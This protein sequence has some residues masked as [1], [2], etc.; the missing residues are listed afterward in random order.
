MILPHL[1]ITLFALLSAAANAF[2]DEA[3]YVPGE[4]LVKYKE[5]TSD[6]DR[7]GFEKKEKLTLIVLIKSVKV[8]LYRLPEGVTVDDAI[9]AFSSLQI[10]EYAEPNFIRKPQA[11]NDPRYNEQWYLHNSGQEVNGMVGPAGVDIRWPEAM[12]IF[13]GTKDVVVAVVDSGVAVTHRELLPNTWFNL[14]EVDGSPGVD[15][16]GNGRIDDR[17]GYD[18]FDNDTSPFDENFH[19]T[20][21]ASVIAAQGNNA[22]GVVGVCPRAKVMAIRIFSQFGESQLPSFGKASDLAQSLEYARL[23][24]ARI[25]NLSLGGGGFS[26]LEL[27]MVR[28]LRDEGILV[29]ASAGNDRADNDQQLF[30]PASYDSANIIAVAAQDRSGGLASF[31]NFGRTQVDIAAPGT[32]ILGADVSREVIYAAD[33][34]ANAAGW[35]TGAHPG[36]LSSK[37]WT[38][39]SDGKLADNPTGTSYDPNSNTYVTSPRIAFGATGSRLS[40]EAAYSL[41]DDRVEVSI[42]VDGLPWERLE[43]IEGFSFGKRA[44]ALDLARFDGRVGYIRFTLISNGFVQGS[45]I[46]I[47][48]FTV[49]SIKVLNPDNPEFNFNEGTSFS[50]PMVSGVAALIMSQRPDIHAAAVRNAILS[51]ARP[52]QALAGKVVTG[53]MLDAEAALKYAMA[54]PT[55]PVFTSQPTPRS[56]AV[57]QSVTFSAGIASPVTPTYQ[58]YRNG[59]AI[60]GATSATLSLSN[61]QASSAGSYSVVVANAGGFVRSSEAALTVLTGPQGWLSNLSVRTSLDA[62]QPLIVGLVVKG[63]SKG[64]LIRA[65]GPALSAF[66]V[67]DVMSDPRLTIY[68]GGVQVA[69]NDNWPSTLAST[70]QSVGAFS[71]PNGSFDSAILRTTVGSETVH[72]LGG[73]PGVVLVE[74]YDTSSNGLAR[75]SNVSA[76]NR[77]SAGAGVLIAGFTVSG[78][79]PANLLIRGIGPALS[80][81]GVSNV[82]RNPQ[83]RAYDSAGRQVAS[84]DDWLPQQSSTFAATGAFALPA[85]SL[86]A[87]LAV[88][89]PPGSY[90]IHVSG[91][92]GGTGEALVEIY[93]IP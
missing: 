24:N 67:P 65:A 88:Q 68:N 82:L 2:A 54:L 39:L 69:T 78:T 23:S 73:S 40:F 53:G 61:V 77:V 17:Y 50:A 43:T 33:F 20:L 47:S 92:D 70:F 49:K 11:F 41:W 51:T 93:E 8:R 18:F 38:L 87:A 86:D 31:S 64:L 30:Y 16:D 46:Q 81:F 25:V 75:L 79:G 58:W 57:G 34:R 28:A 89:V 52:V 62:N 45:G 15:D 3:V 66:G 74:A 22:L 19:G 1:R 84:N 14:P 63:G 48:T 21:V 85:G 32:E 90:T 29:I 6:V 36:N 7:E 10:I 27:S 72:V 60:P 59:V 42:S 37:V 35:T 44:F 55:P 5:G 9:K 76:R 80:T 12:G 26:L 91:S 83:I 71:F 4:V 56:A 13:T